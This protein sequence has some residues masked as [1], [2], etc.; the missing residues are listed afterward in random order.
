VRLCI[1][2]TAALTFSKILSAGGRETARRQWSLSVRPASGRIW[3][4]SQW[5]MTRALTVACTTWCGSSVCLFHKSLA[6]TCLVL[7]SR[8][9]PL[10]HCYARTHART[11]A[12]T[13]ARSHARTL[14]R[15]LART[16]AR[17]LARTLART[18]TRT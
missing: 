3:R 18:R 15:T 2:A 5:R 13:L 9:V 17:T 4:V 12:R 10:F 7:P 11:L 8:C 14:A 6:L 16:P 1:Q